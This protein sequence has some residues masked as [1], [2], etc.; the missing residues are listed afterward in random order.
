MQY[1]L[2]LDSTQDGQR[3]KL[4]RH[5]RPLQDRD[6]LSPP[7]KHDRKTNNEHESP[8]SKRRGERGPDGDMKRERA[9]NRKPNNDSDEDTTVDD[10]SFDDLEPSSAHFAEVVPM[11]RCIDMSLRCPIEVTSQPLMHYGV[12]SVLLYS[13]CP[14]F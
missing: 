2:S 8:G 4:D 12:T 10:V 7:Y 3:G 9:S 14:S 1:H 5:G 13:V 6:E 11:P